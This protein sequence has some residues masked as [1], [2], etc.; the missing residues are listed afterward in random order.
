MEIVKL[1]FLSEKP[2]VSAAV[3]GESQSIRLLEEL[4]D[5][6]NRFFSLSID[7]LKVE[8]TCQ[9]KIEELQKLSSECDDPN[10]K[11]YITTCLFIISPISRL[12]LY[13]SATN[14]PPVSPLETTASQKS[15]N[16]QKKDTP[17]LYSAISCAIRL[18]CGG[19][20]VALVDTLQ[21]T[22]KFAS[23][24]LMNLNK[25]ESSKASPATE[26]RRVTRTIEKRNLLYS[27]NE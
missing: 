3:E 9:A 22:P 4:R 11:Q 24:S 12:L 18:L 10:L 17:Q 16:V 13:N 20:G 15:Q 26:R 2:I 23:S 25:R 6:I 27:L 19:L 14:I 1:R 8:T 7:D 21:E 5:F